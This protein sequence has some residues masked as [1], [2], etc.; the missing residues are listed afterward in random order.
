MELQKFIESS[1]SQIVSGI[2]NVGDTA[3]ESGAL[4]NPRQDTWRYGE[5]IYFDSKTGSVLTNIEFDIAV[6]A[7]EGEKKKEGIGVAIA[8]VVLGTQN[9]SE[10]ENEQVSRIKF[11]IPVVLPSSESKPK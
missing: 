4:L 10:K 6:T 7:T 1:I 11:S 3:K 8:S 9:Q 5:G 2:A